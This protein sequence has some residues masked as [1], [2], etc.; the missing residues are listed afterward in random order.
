MGHWRLFLLL[1]TILTSPFTGRCLRG[2]CAFDPAASSPVG[3]VTLLGESA[4][5]QSFFGG[6]ITDPLEF[7]AWLSKQCGE[8]S[9]LMMLGE[10]DG[11]HIVAEEQGEHEVPNPPK[12]FEAANPGADAKQFEAANPGADA[13]QFEAANPGADAPREERATTQHSA[14]QRQLSSPS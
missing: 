8:S 6:E 4:G 13:K 12:Q 1:F 14:E 5:L 10:V 11:C 2:Y 9:H 7:N 3:A